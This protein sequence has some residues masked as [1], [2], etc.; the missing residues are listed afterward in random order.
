MQ[1]YVFLD[2]S[3]ATRWKSFTTRC[4]V[5][6]RRLRNAALKAQSIASHTFKLSTPK[7]L[8]INQK[9]NSNIKVCSTILCIF[10][11]SSMHPKIMRYP[12]LE[13]KLLC[14]NKYLESISPTF[15]SAFAPIFLHQ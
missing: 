1:I 13:R 11:S 4:R 3:S 6:T 15:L 7:R 10:D 5:A 9:L 2:K 12:I 14:S 8:A